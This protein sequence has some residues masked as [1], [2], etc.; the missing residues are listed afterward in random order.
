MGVVM[1]IIIGCRKGIFGN[2]GHMWAL[3]CNRTHLK[4]ALCHICMVV[5]WMI[6]N[7]RV[8]TLGIIDLFQ[9]QLDENMDSHWL[10]THK[11]GIL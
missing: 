9:H 8:S 10:Q 6:N 1:L 11:T 7:Q 3:P 5:E 2:A 4:M